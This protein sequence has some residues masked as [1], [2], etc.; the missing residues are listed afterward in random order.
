MSGDG[1]RRGE[2]TDRRHG[3]PEDEEG[4]REVCSAKAQQHYFAASA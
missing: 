2:N 3:P 1:W 4:I